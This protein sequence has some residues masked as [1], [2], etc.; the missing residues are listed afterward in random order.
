MRSL[1][2]TQPL[3]KDV[4][5]VDQDADVQQV[6]P[7]LCPGVGVQQPAPAWKMRSHVLSTKQAADGC[8]VQRNNY[9]PLLLKLCFAKKVKPL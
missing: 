6:I 8:S 2:E 9:S 4:E 5:Q 1:I 7:L 3:G